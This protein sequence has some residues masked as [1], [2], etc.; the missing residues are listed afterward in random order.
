MTE[1]GKD[2]S[3]TSDRCRKWGVISTWEASIA[4]LCVVAI[5]WWG[6]YALSDPRWR[7]NEINAAAAL[8]AYAMAQIIFR[9]KDYCRIPG[10]SSPEL[11]ESAFADNF[12]NLHYGHDET[13]TGQL[14]LIS[15]HFADAF[16]VDNALS[17][18]ATVGDA[19]KTPTPYQGYLFQED[20]SG[21][22]PASQYGNKF[23]LMAFPAVYGVDG[24]SV[25]WI[26]E[27]GTVH[28]SKPDVK[29]GAT[30]TEIQ[31]L[32]SCPTPLIERPSREW[33][34]FSP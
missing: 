17:G 8:K 25:F 22:L 1:V 5:Y 29:K 14:Q 15:K 26:G 18:A 33:Q 10:N 34:I 2:K 21:S 19:P 23:A 6:L 20:C 24:Y 27:T 30:A 9:K 7:A 12:R 28:E 4:F 16:L 31:R 3:A 13:G 32:Y 11:G